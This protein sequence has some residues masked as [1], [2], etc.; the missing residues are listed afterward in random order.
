VKLADGPVMNLHFAKPGAIMSA[1][2]AL[3]GT[4]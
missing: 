3:C 4:S 1:K 2:P